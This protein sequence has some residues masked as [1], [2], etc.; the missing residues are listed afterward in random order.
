MLPWFLTF[1][2]TVTGDDTVGLEGENVS[3]YAL[4]S[5]EPLPPTVTVLLIWLF[6]SFDS[7]IAPVVSVMILRVC[8][9]ALSVPMSLD[10]VV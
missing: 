4:R 9:P 8:V 7:V 5:G 10:A 2:A 3:S 6:D 1:H